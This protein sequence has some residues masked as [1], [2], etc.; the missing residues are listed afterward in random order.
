MKE[1]MDCKNVKAVESLL[2]KLKLTNSIID[3][4]DTLEK[5]RQN[6]ILNFPQG[7]RQNRYSYWKV[8][9]EDTCNEGCS[10]LDYISRVVY[11]FGPYDKTCTTVC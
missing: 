10:N 8:N 2:Y 5:Y 6:G 4:Y 3:L 9:V 7:R 11:R 1:E